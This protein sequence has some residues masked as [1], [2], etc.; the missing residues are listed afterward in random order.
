[1][2]GGIA[3][4]DSR[5]TGGASAGHGSRASAG[6]SSTGR[7]TAGRSSATMCS[8]SYGGSTVAAHAGGKG[9]RGRRIYAR[10]RGRFGDIG[11]EIAAGGTARRS[12][13]SAMRHALVSPRR[14]VPIAPKN[15]WPI[16]LLPASVDVVRWRR[17]PHLRLSTSPPSPASAD[18]ATVV[19]LRLSASPLSSAYIC[20]R[21]HRQMHLSAPSP[22]PASV[23]AAAVVRLRPPTPPP[24]PASAGVLIPLWPPPSPSCRRH[25]LHP[26]PWLSS[27]AAAAVVVAASAA[28]VALVYPGRRR[29]HRLH[30]Q[31][32]LSSIAAAAV[33]VAAFAAAVTIIHPG[34]CHHVVPITCFSLGRG[35]HQPRPWP[36]RR[37]R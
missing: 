19:R 21:R 7:S 32:W 10:E 11:G 5:P 15:R 14:A 25:R 9:E 27:T 23:G 13:A 6:S 8:S 37:G 35:P 31:P 1:M 12:H 28:T 30:P 18:A 36:R 20:R 2:G 24:S 4:A 17:R 3:S 26:L 33:V 34:H 16:W 29:C 22:S